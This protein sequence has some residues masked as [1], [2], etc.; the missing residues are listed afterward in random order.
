MEECSDIFDCLADIQYE[1]EERGYTIEEQ[2]G[3]PPGNVVSED[4]LYKLR[5]RGSPNQPIYSELHIGVKKDYVKKLK[6]K[7]ME[8]KGARGFKTGNWLATLL[9]YPAPTP[10]IRYQ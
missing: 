9:L 3:F 1:R 8:T 4:K 2:K 5:A 10:V 7:Y 6:K